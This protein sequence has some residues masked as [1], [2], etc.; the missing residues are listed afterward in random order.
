MDDNVNIARL[1]LSLGS[2]PDTVG[3]GSKKPRKGKGS[4][5]VSGRKGDSKK[6]HPAGGDRKVSLPAS[7]VRGCTSATCSPPPV[8]I[9]RPP[10]VQVRNPVF[11][12]EFSQPPP[13]KRTPKPCQVKGCGEQIALYNPM[14]K[15]WECLHH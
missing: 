1:L 12:F 7:M 11:A 14:K 8:V 9:T 15:R 5:V 2:L 6:S 13:H 4:A 10:R 3:D